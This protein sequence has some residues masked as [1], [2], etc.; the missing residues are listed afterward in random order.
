MR[1]I[2][3]ALA[4]GLPLP[5]HAQPACNRPV[6]PDLIIAD[7]LAPANYTATDG[8]DAFA[9]GTRQTDVG[10][11]WINSQVMPP[12]ASAHPVITQNLFRLRAG[13]IGRFE[14]LGQSW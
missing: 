9:V 1:R 12:L 8:R 3:I 6:G 7:L 5:A 2:A 11:S 4:A 14:Q 13:G 10:N